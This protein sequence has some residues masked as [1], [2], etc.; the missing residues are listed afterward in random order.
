MIVNYLYMVVVK[1]MRIILK[2]DMF[3]CSDVV[4]RNVGFFYV[5][6]KCFK[7]G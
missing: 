2:W 3:V 5:E 7:F 6:Y 1:V 4:E